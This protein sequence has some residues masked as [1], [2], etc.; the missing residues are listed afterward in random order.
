MRRSTRSREAMDEVAED[1]TRFALKSLA[2]RKFR[3]VLTA[4]AI[5]LGVAM[6]S[7]TYVL[8]D[9]IDKAFSSIFDE[10]YAGTDAVVSGKGADIDVDGDT[11]PRPA[12]RRLAPR[13]RPR[14]STTSGSRWAASTTRRTRRSSAT[15]ARRSNTNGAPSFGFGIDTAP[16]YRRFNPLNLLEGRW[17]AG[18][19]TRSSSTPGTADR[20][21]LHGRRHRSRSRR[22]SR[23]RTSRSSASPS[24]GDVEVA[25]DRDVRDLRHRDGA[26]ALRPRRAVRRHLRRRRRR[27][28]PEQLVG[29]DPAAPPGRRARSKTGAAGGAG[30]Q[31]RHQRV[32]GVHPVLPARL[33]RHRALRRRVRH[34]QHALDHGRAADARV[35]DA[36]DARRLAPADAPL[37]DP[38][39]A[40]DRAPRVAHRPLRS[41]RARGGAQGALPARSVSSSRPPSTVFATR[42]IVVS[43]L[44][45]TIITLARRALPRD[46]RDARA[47]DRGRP[48][49]RDAAEGPALAASRRTSRSSLIALALF[50]LGYSMFADDLDTAAAAPLDRRRRDPALHRRRDDLVAARPAARGGRR[51]AGAVDRRRRRAGSRAGTRCATRAAR[52][53]RRRR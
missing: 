39:G 17:P 52:P 45:G 33:R 20:R 13:R 1:V 3:T 6:I 30:G 27:A 50:L 49:G 8:T 53:R 14:R 24:Y 21:G 42:T 10:S 7:G 36:A 23:S 41:A 46:P 12:G 29:D 44:V 5:V 51:A 26:E 40:R 22:C 11:P 25:R 19:R 43:L 38:R 4:L 15:T 18:R 47:A 35:R 34:L 37:R 48:R 16:E 31:G 9:T 2:G 28:T 32:H